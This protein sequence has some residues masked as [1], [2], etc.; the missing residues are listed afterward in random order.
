MR[1]E[2]AHALEMQR[3]LA[4]NVKSPKA[5][6]DL[7][8]RHAQDK[9]LDPEQDVG[10]AGVKSASDRTP[11]VTRHASSNVTQ[12]ASSPGNQTVDSKSLLTKDNLLVGTLI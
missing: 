8:G 12:N 10:L 11:N 2:E 4:M 7:R 6:H 3:C 5:A 1:Y 9:L